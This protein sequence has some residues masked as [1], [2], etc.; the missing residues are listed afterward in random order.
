MKNLDVAHYL[1]LDD[2]NPIGLSIDDEL[3]WFSDYE[4]V[5][6][7]YHDYIIQRISLDRNDE[8]LIY[9]RLEI[10]SPTEE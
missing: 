6:E 8:G 1:D 10:L 2:D 4:P 7:E 9:I 3:V 5:P